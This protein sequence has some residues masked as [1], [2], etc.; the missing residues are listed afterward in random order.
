[1]SAEAGNR[2]PRVKRGAPGAAGCRLAPWKPILVGLAG[3]AIALVMCFVVY[4]EVSRSYRTGRDAD[5][6][7]VLGLNL[8]RG[9]GLTFDPAAGP[10][11]YRG[12][13]YPAFIMLTQLVSG[14]WYPQAVWIAQSLLHGLTCVFTFL[15]TGRLVSGRLA[16]LTALA[17]AAYPVLFWYA[18]RM[19]N[20]SL[21]MPMVAG[22]ALAGVRQVERPGMRMSLLIG[23][24][25]GL[26]SLVK[27]TFLPMVVVVPLVL[28][29]SSSPRS[30]RHTAM[31]IVV[32][33]L[34]ILPWSYR[35]YNLTH[36]FIP[37]HTGTG[38]NMY[39]GNVYGRELWSDPL[40]YSRIWDRH[41]TP[42]LSAIRGLRGVQWVK[43][44]E[45]D[46]YF[47]HLAVEELRRDP[48]LVLKKASAAALMFWLAGDTPPKT[49]VVLL[50]RLPVLALGFWGAG[51][52]IRR[53]DR[54]FIAVLAFVLAYWLVH[55]PFGGPARLS[56]PVMP[57]MVVFASVACARI[58]A[59]FSPRNR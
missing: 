7:G 43:D 53:R 9:L 14:G 52:L 38:L 16:L 44:V 47:R 41:V 42:G 31:M 6:Y 49:M 13:L 32:A 36:R 21:L 48:S 20:E 39:V 55:L 17:A 10:T 25:L 58:A 56:A 51:L 28:H 15:L 11:V 30:R 8:W 35:N 4:A 12:V 33:G 1:M 34:A 5:N 19:W 22:L 37:V 59:A 2:Q 29:V 3:T 40:S 27:A 26:L 24:L 46:R 18:P 54:R 50:L 57:L 45:G 23:L